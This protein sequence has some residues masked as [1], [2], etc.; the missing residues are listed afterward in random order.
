MPSPVLPLLALIAV[1]VR[2]FLRC[3]GFL[4]LFHLIQGDSNML[5]GTS[6]LRSNRKAL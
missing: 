4:F 5:I 1:A 2:F 6:V 3:T